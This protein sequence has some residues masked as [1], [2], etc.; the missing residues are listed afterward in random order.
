[1]A[2][3]TAAGGA[4]LLCRVACLQGQLMRNMASFAHSSCQEG[5]YRTGGGVLTRAYLTTCQSRNTLFQ[6]PPPGRLVAGD[7]IATRK[8]LPKRKAL[9]SSRLETANQ[10][11]LPFLAEMRLSTSCQ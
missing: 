7:S 8:T 2:G 9:R 4:G 6:C 1:M 5:T 3:C 10:R 11:E